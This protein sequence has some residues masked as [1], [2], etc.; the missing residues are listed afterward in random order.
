MKTKRHGCVSPVGKPALQRAL[1]NARNG[2][3]GK[4]CITTCGAAHLAHGG[5]LLDVLGAAHDEPG[6]REELPSSVPLHLLVDEQLVR[7]RL[8]GAEAQ[9]KAWATFPSDRSHTIAL[10]SRGQERTPCGKSPR[11]VSQWAALSSRLLLVVAA[12]ALLQPADGPVSERHRRGALG[13]QL[14]ILDSETDMAR[15]DRQTQNI[16]FTHNSKHVG[17]MVP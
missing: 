11:M 3:H 2:A 6:R 16:V 7:H 17:S 14:C 5:G 1:C 13:V 15:R 8:R 12:L 9:T 4:V 10:V